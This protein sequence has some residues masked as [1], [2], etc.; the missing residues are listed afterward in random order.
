[1]RC[2]MPV[3]DRK[4]PRRALGRAPEELTLEER[5]L[6]T[7]KSIALEIY[8]PSTLPLRRIAA[9]GDSVAECV[10]MLQ[11]RG[12][13]PKDFEYDRITPPY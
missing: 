1:M 3:P 13:D 8:T 7:G 11:E 2:M 4:D 9:V 10:R 5:T 12:F 6:F